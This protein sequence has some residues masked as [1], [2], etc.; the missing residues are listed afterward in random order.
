LA[1]TAATRRAVWAIWGLGFG[2]FAFYVPYSGLTVALSK[3]LLPGLAGP[4]SGFTILPAAALGSALSMPFFLA[5]T[6]WWKRAGRRRVAG[7]EIPWPGRWPLV[8][9]LSTAFIIG[10]TTLNF[11]FPGVSIVFMLLLMRAGTLTLSPIVDSL[12]GRGIRWYSWTALALS[13]AA[14]AVAVADVGSYALT[15]VAGCSLACYLAG[16]VGRFEVMSRHGKVPDEA[17]NR[18]FFVEE[19]MASTP[20]LVA[21]L[22]LGALLAPGPI[23]A[24]LRAG[25]TGFLASPAA[26]PAFAIGVLYEG[27][28]VFGS[29]IYLDHREYTYCVPVNRGASLVAGLVAAYALALAFGHPPPATSA[30]AGLGLILVAMGFLAVPPALELRAAAAGVGAERAVGRLLQ[31]AFLFV[32]GGNT[33][34]SPMAAALCSAELAARLGISPEKLAAAGVWVG[35]AGVAAHEGAP[36]SAGARRALGR[37]GVAAPEHR[38]RPLTAADVA[39]AGAVFCMTEAQRRQVLALTPEAAARVHR[40]DPEGDVEDPEGRDDEVFQ[41]CARR[42][43]ELVRAR[44]AAQLAPSPGT[45]LG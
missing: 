15:A 1:S 28:F 6:G 34:R 35:S 12:H 38:A 8:S 29:L 23:G 21:V 19:H 17:A 41:R 18:R 36:L 27:L 31:G 5:A 33:S 40:L 13:L 30:L 3:G 25:F 4:V 32:C 14:A 16:Y 44:L 10:A 7:V 2:Y 9:A 42:L 39:R 43:R 24:E 45:T 26:I 11:T 20:L 22:A 37:L